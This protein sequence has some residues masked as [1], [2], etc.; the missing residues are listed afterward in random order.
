MSDLAVSGLV[1]TVDVVSRCPFNTSGLLVV[2]PSTAFSYKVGGATPG[3]TFSMIAQ[4]QVTSQKNGGVPGI[5]WKINEDTR[6][7]AD[8][9]DCAGSWV[10]IDLESDAT[11]SWNTSVGSIVADLQLSDF[12]YNTSLANCYQQY[13]DKSISHLVVWS[14]L[15][16]NNVLEVWDVRASLLTTAG[17]YGDKIMKNYLCHMDA[18]PIDWALR[19]IMSGA[20]LLF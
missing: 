8:S 14:T 17:S 5:Y 2:M 6:F 11:Y 10:C 18:A 12:L 4:S 1:R 19:Q 16:S 15:V 13:P 3:P 7:R 20:A 9:R